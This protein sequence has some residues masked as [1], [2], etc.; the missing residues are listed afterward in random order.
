MSDISDLTDATEWAPKYIVGQKI[1][2]ITTIR[3]PG[4][5]NQQMIPGVFYAEVIS[6]DKSQQEYMLKIN[7]YDGNPISG[8]NII[9]TANLAELFPTIADFERNSRLVPEPPRIRPKYY[10][11][12]VRPKQHK[13]CVIQ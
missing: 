1:K 10:K 4:D 12:V 8:G 11:R 7:V 3:I 6:I 9:S 13:A 2:W 5:E